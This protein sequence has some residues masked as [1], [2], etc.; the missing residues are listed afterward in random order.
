MRGEQMAINLMGVDV[1]FSTTR[2]TTG[3][4]CLDGDRLHLERAGTAWEGREAKI[5]HGF[6]PFVIAIDGPLLPKGSAL[7]IRRHV[8]SVFIRAPFH[9]RCRPGLSHHGVGLELREASS[10]ACAQFSR[11]LAASVSANSGTVRREGPIVEAF[12]N[13]FLGVLMPEV[14]LLSA[15]RLK[16]GRRFDWLYELMVTTGRLESVLSKNL[17]LPDEV[18][19]RLRLERDHELRAALICLLTAALAAQGTA[20]II[21]EAEGG[22]FWLPPWTLWQPWA[23]E[24]LEN[25]A[26]RIALKATCV[27]DRP[28]T[29]S[30]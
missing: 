23:T 6:Q 7:N 20:T 5:P 18:W 3:I 10:D 24:G 30:L 13:A 29:M 16:R 12:P 28:F 26:K 21:G 9:N 15:P 27:L 19:H 14:E 17:D 4:A 11:I 2:P 1:G 8:E 25:A 22:W